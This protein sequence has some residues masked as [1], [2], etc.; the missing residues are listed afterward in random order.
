MIEN[1]NNYVYSQPQSEPASL[2]HML[3]G[4]MQGVYMYMFIGLMATAFASYTA[5]SHIP[6]RIWVMESFLVL[7]IVELVLVFALGFFIHKMPFAASLGIF[8]GYAILNG[9][10]LCGIFIV[11]EM[12]SIAAAFFTTALTFGIMS[13]Y[14]YFAKKD[15]TGIG[16]LCFMGL[17]GIII[18]MVI[19]MFLGSE[20]MDYIISAVAILVFIG[21]TAYDTQKIKK[22]LSE[23]S[24]ELAI[25]RITI[26][27]ALQLYLDFINIFLHLL[28]FMG[29]RN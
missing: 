24:N 11:Y 29:K 20:T 10:T 21:L 6:L 13:A 5:F 28:R 8:L 26:W 2:S 9:L 16:S 22:R 18:A 25:K 17:I 7:I 15:L 27:G 4:V 1:N 23:E 19:N 12:G 3:T 14:G